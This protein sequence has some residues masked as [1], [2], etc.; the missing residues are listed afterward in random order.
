MKTKIRSYTATHLSLYHLTCRQHK[1]KANVYVISMKIHMC[2]C[3]RAWNFDFL[4]IFY[5]LITHIYMASHSWHAIFNKATHRKIDSFVR[6]LHLKK[7]RSK[8]TADKGFFLSRLENNTRFDREYIKK[9]I[10]LQPIRIRSHGESPFCHFKH[11]YS[12]R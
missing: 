3:A 2:V 6:S 5:F 10:T 1:N 4:G 11:S 7:K 9:G 12:Y 8:Y